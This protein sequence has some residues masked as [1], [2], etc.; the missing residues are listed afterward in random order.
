ML[1]S[2]ERLRKHGLFQRAYAAKKT[3]STPLLSLYVLEREARSAPKLPLVGF[4]IGKKA[5]AK[6]NQRNRA[7]RRV[8]EAYRL[9]RKDLEGPGGEGEINL[10]QW[11]AIVW[12]VKSE[13][14]SASFEDISASVSE[15]LIKADSKFGKG[16]RKQSKGKQSR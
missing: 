3:V 2:Q 13:V 6:A 10:K 12:V 8:R 7:K 5:E 15:C 16:A 1:S 11:Y 9:L 4:V 14:L